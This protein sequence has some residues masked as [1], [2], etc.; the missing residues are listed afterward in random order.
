M[1]RTPACVALVA[2]LLA[3]PAL[4]AGELPDNE[5]G[6]VNYHL[7]NPELA[8]GGKVDPEALT[9]LQGQGLQTVV[10]IRHPDEGTAEEKQQVEEL[11]LKYVSVPVTPDSFT[12]EDARRI[13]EILGDAGPAL[14]H[15]ASGN[16]V[17][18]VWAVVRGLEG[19]DVEQALSEG[20]A[21]GLR[22]K[23]MI[24]ATRRVLESLPPDKP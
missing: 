8:F 17:G 16:R 12:A 23:G 5:T 4:V 24:E 19:A 7:V 21:A 2:V 15:C 6:V 13:Q 18:G 1:N 3:P 10:D 22:S 14:L 9:R 20:Q 11:G